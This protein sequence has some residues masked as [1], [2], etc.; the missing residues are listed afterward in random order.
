MGQNEITLLLC[1]SG[2]DVIENCK[3]DENYMTFSDKN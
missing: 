2:I 3:I 1:I